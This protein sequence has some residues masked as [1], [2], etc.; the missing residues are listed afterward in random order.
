[1]TTVSTLY[2][3]SL[4]EVAFFGFTFVFAIVLIQTFLVYK[5]T[6]DIKPLYDLTC[7]Y[8]YITC[9]KATKE[10]FLKKMLI[11]ALFVLFYK[12]FYPALQSGEQFF[13]VLLSVFAEKTDTDRAVRL[14]RGQ[15]HRGHR[16]RYARVM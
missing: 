8:Q 6:F 12:V 9:D 3:T 1:M 13:R 5:K 2:H 15:P 10:Q 4:F 14:T 16:T 11:Y 7:S